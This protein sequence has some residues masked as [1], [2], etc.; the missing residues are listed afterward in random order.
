VPTPEEKAALA[1]A[2]EPVQGWF[3][4]N[5]DGGNEILD[6]LIA[7]VADAEADLAAQYESDLN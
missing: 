3:R 5:V 1:T 2:A 6:A 7:A 4:E